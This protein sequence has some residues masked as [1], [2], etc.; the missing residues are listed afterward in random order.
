MQAKPTP[1][2]MGS[3]M[4]GEYHF[5]AT[6][7][8]P[9]GTQMMMHEKPN[10]RRTWG[11]N[12]KKAWYLGPCFKHYRSVRGLVP[13]IGGE[14]I[15]DTYRFKHHAIEIPQLTPADRILKAAKQFDAAI[16][17]QPKK[18]PMGVLTAIQLLRVV[19]LG[20]NTQPLPSNS[21]QR[22]KSA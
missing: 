21:V 7:I 15:S 4:E 2:G 5:D 18:A 19:L 16:T 13:S 10:R 17:Q 1:L 9:P 22:R 8:S 3:I 14:R 20:K 12:A 11:F 6:P